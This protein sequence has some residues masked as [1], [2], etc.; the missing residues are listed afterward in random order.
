MAN[1]KDK[2]VDQVLRKKKYQNPKLII[3]G[4][5]KKITKSIG[6]TG[7][8]DGHPGAHSHTGV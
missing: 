4:D 3:Y 6:R 8:P 1:K 7:N 2:E 5:I